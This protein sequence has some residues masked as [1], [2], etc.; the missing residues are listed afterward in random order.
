MHHSFFTSLTSPCW[1]QSALCL[2][3]HSCDVQL[4]EA[5]I[6]SSACL[7]VAATPR[8][9]HQSVAM[10]VMCALKVLEVLYNSSACAGLTA[11]QRMTCCGFAVVSRSRARNNQVQ[12]S[13]SVSL[14]VGDCLACSEATGCARAT[15]LGYHWR[16]KP[17]HAW[18]PR[19]RHTRPMS[20]RMTHP[21]LAGYAVPC[22]RNT[23]RAG[24]CICTRLPVIVCLLCSLYDWSRARQIADCRLHV[25]M[26]CNANFAATNSLL[27]AIAALGRL[28]PT[29]LLSS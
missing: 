19:T 27:L 9:R 24:P 7:S 13:G 14:C 20:H 22:A 29:G 6:Q 1:S 4:N 15:G 8:P 26:C 17:C 18:V 21:P 5:A 23:A 2:H 3:R 25:A 10:S 12:S 11:L 28:L 16:A